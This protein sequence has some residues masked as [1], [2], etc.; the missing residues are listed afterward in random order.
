M[1]PDPDMILF[2]LDK[3][4]NDYEV[5]KF[6]LTNPHQEQTWAVLN[7]LPASLNIN[8]NLIDAENTPGED[9]EIYAEILRSSTYQVPELKA[10]PDKIRRKFGSDICWVYWAGIFD[11]PLTDDQRTILIHYRTAFLCLL[12]NGFIENANHI[13]KM[14]EYPQTCEEKRITGAFLYSRDVLRGTLTK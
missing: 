9:F 8:L 2:W 1:T 12:V 7:V 10:Y 11:R 5:L 13:L 3:F 14:A 6:I 4:G